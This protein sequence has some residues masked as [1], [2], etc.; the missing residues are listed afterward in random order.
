VISGSCSL[1]TSRQIDW[2]S[3][4]GFQTLHASP[5]EILDHLRGKPF[6][7]SLIHQLTAILDRGEDAVLDTYFDSPSGFAGESLGTALGLM[8]RNLLSTTSIAR[9]VLCGGDTSS[10]AVQQ[11]G[12]T[13]LTWKASLQPGA[14]LCQVHFA[15]CRDRPLELVLKGGQIGSDDFFAIAKGAQSLQLHDSSRANQASRKP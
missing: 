2:A 10:H 6:Q 5:T 1:A 3:R 11:L 7:D 12:I 9:V 8:L 15:E 14:P 4:N 13:A